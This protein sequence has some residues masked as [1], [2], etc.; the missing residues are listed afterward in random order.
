MTRLI[1]IVAFAF[2]QVWVQSPASGCLP[3]QVATAG[4][5]IP[6]SRDNPG[7]PEHLEIYHCKT[8]ETITGVRT[9][10]AG[11]ITERQV[12]VTDGSPA[13]AWQPDTAYLISG[14]CLYRLHSGD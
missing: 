6:A 5:T 8:H 10:P 14:D 13:S 12:R 11:T 9:I 4:Y 2:I 3:L 7:D 1:C